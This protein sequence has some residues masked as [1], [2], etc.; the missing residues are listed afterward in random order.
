MQS[1][2]YSILLFKLYVFLESA[3]VFG[4]LD[5]GQELNESKVQFFDTYKHV[6]YWLFTRL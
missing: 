6:F 2:I 4:E 3:S 1:K 5:G